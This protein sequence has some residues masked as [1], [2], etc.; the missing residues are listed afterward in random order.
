MRMKIKCVRWGAASAGNAFTSDEKDSVDRNVNLLYRSSVQNGL[1]SVA[2]TSIATCSV[3]YGRIQGTVVELLTRQV[4]LSLGLEFT[5]F[6][7]GQL[8]FKNE[9]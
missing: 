7:C 1:Q 9:S 2:K 5:I 8:T 4:L 6:L 3:A